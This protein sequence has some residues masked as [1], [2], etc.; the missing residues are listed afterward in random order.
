MYLLIIIISTLMNSIV[1]FDFN[2]N[3]NVNKWKTVDDNVM[4]GISSSSITIN[5]IGNGLFAGHVSLAN[6]GGFSSVRY[7]PKTIGLTNKKSF[8][9]KIKGDGKN[10]QFRVKSSLN[11]SHSY[12]YL[13]NTNSEWQTIEIP[14]F[15]LSPTFR[16]RDLRIPNFP[17]LQIEEI[18]F[19][20]SNKKE[21][22]FNLEIDFIK[23]K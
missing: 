13:I 12:K 16:G 19:L 4:G 9:I 21:E 22:N 18:C 20:I 2:N 14:F 10:Y 5:K 7:Q 1:I 15:N 8:L 11:E 23:T 6:N 3:T 17:G